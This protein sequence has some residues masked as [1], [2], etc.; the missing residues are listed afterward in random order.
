MRVEPPHVSRRDQ[1]RR[2][3]EC[4]AIHGTRN[5]VHRASHHAGCSIAT[6]DE[7]AV[8][9]RVLA[10]ECSRAHAEALAA[11]DSVAHRCG[12]AGRSAPRSARSPRRD[13]RPP[14]GSP[15]GPL[16]RRIRARPTACCRAAGPTRL[17]SSLTSTTRPLVRVSSIQPVFLRRRVPWTTHLSVRMPVYGTRS[18][19]DS[20]S[21]GYRGPPSSST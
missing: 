8:N 17:S 12:P 11:A 19:F 18:D 20:E 1:R 14:V 5:R 4:W 7:R 9:H 2:W 21:D 16:T 13:C 15:S 6:A 3:H 10:V